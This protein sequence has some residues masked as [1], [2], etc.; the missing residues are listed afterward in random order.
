MIQITIII[1]GKESLQL[2]EQIN[3]MLF[4][5]SARGSVVVRKFDLDNPAPKPEQEKMTGK[6]KYPDLYRKERQYCKERKGDPYG[7][8]AIQQ[9]RHNGPADAQNTCMC[10]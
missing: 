1:E 10:T 2:S 7:K 4:D 8:K 5:A 6:L 3:A 9:E